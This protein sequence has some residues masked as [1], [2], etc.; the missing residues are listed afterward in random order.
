MEGWNGFTLIPNVDG[1]QVPFVSD[2]SGSSG[3]G[4]YWGTHGFQW[5]WEGQA[6]DWSI[7]PKELLPIIIGVTV[8]GKCWAGSRV[9]CFCDNAEVVAVVNS[10]KAIDAPP[11]MYV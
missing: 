5:R 1:Q 6:A 7:A 3:C 9:E 8:Y 2:A 10:G 11:E 4:A